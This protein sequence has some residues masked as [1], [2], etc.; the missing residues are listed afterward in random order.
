MRRSRKRF[1][2]QPSAPREWQPHGRGHSLLLNGPWAPSPDSELKWVTSSGG[3][4][5]QVLQLHIYTDLVQLLTWIIW[6]HSNIPF[7]FAVTLFTPVAAHFQNMGLTVRASST[8]HISIKGIRCNTVN[9]PA[10]F[11]MS[12]VMSFWLLTASSMPILQF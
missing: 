7:S 6:K 4:K 10:I 2:I 8:L 1:L 5:S 11:R 3:N 12:N 9:F